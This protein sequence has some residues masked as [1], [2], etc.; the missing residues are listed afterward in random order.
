MR[1]GTVEIRITRH[2][3][4][5]H[6]WHFELDHL[7]VQ[8]IPAP[9]GQRRTSPIAVRR[10]WI[11]VAADETVLFNAALQLGDAIGRRYTRRL[12]QLTHAD[13]VL[14]EQR[15]HAVYEVVHGRGPLAAG[16]LVAIVVGHATG[17]R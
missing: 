5:N 9:V 14:G 7:L 17:R 4:V 2:A 3:H 6:R 8:R 1:T 10:I 16:L 13:E 12:W 11:Q 15:A